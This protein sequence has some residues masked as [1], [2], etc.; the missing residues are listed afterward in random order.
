MG[1]KFACKFACKN[2]YESQKLYHTTA[3]LNKDT[4]T[5]KIQEFKVNL[6]H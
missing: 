5:I 1:V 2:V 4:A 6:L 3:E